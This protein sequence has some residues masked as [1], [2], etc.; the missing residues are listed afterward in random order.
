MVSEFSETCGFYDETL[1]G[2]QILCF[3]KSKRANERRDTVVNVAETP[4]CRNEDV[5]S[6]SKRMCVG[7]DVSAYSS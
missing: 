4:T 6:I 5:L 2:D 1:P 7:C 3:G